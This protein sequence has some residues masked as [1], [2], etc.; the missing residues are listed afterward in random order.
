MEKD[1][2][3]VKISL[4]KLDDNH[5]R[6][7]DSIL[8]NNLNRIIEYLGC[9]KSINII[10]NL[11]QE[12]LLTIIDENIKQLLSKIVRK[13]LEKNME[14]KFTYLFDIIV[15]YLLFEEEVD[16][17]D[18]RICIFLEQICTSDGYLK[19]EAKLLYPLMQLSYFYELFGPFFVRE[20]KISNLKEQD[21][22]IAWNQW[23]FKLLKQAN[24]E[25]LNQISFQFLKRKYWKQEEEIKSVEDIYYFIWNKIQYSWMNEKWQYHENISKEFQKQ[26]VIPPI[27]HTLITRKG[28]CFDIA[29]VVDKFLKHLGFPSRIRMM[30]I[31]EN[32]QIKYH[33]YVL[34]YQN[35]NWYLFNPTSRYINF[36][37]ISS[38]DEE[39]SL[40]HAG[41]ATIDI[42]DLPE[43]IDF[44]FLKE[45]EK[46]V[47]GEARKRID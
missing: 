8:S 7:L 34:F 29:R 28:C 42:A 32:Q 26:Y 22:I 47:F 18:H 23:K 3:I 45:I 1:Y 25:E 21:K 13:I 43:N 39:M 35:H 20:L 33:C 10:F 41:E 38:L 12:E 17:Q 31:R 9:Y 40:F 15:E 24:Q 30:R 5:F 11:E 37:T 6:K 19:K 46:K 36:I 14:K 27:T 44:N 4:N 16:R 2:G